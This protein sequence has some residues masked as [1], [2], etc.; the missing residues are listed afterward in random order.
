M[1]A[2]ILEFQKLKRRRRDLAGATK[3]SCGVLLFSYA[4]RSFGPK[5]LH[6]C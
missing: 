1:A 6:D 5:R 4:K 2:A 3:Q